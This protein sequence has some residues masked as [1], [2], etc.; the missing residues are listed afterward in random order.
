MKNILP[1]FLLIVLFIFLPIKIYSQT[2]VE[3]TQS[4][5]INF[6][7]AQGGF[8]Y[9]GGIACADFNNDNFTDIYI[10][11]A[12]GSPNQLY[13]NNGDLTFTEKGQFADVND[14]NNSW[15]TVAGDIDNDGDID[16]YLTNYK[17]PNRLYINDGTGKFTDNATL[18][19]VTGSVAGSDSGY[20]SSATMADFDNDGYLDI[21]VLNRAQANDDYANNLYHN[22]GDGTFTD[23]TLWANP[24]ELQTA[25]AVGTCDYDNDGYM[26]IYVANEF[27]L[28]GF[29]HNNKNNSFSDLGP[30]L[31]IP[32]TAGMG[33]DYTDFDHDGDFEIYITNLGNDIF[34]VNNGDGTVTNKNSVVGITNGSMTWGVNIADYNNDGYDDIYSVNGGMM[35]PQTYSQ[36]N[37]YYKNL[38]NGTFV[39]KADL[40]GLGS[41]LGD[42]RASSYL[43]INNDGFMDII[44]LNILRDTDNPSD[45]VRGKAHLYLNQG[46]NNNWISL[47]LIGVQSNKSAVGA[48]VKLEAGNLTQL[49][50]VHSGSSFGSMHC[51]E[52]GFGLKDNTI[53]DKLTITWPSGNVQELTNVNVNQILTITENN[54]VTG[55]D[56]IL[57]SPPEEF[58][59]SQNYPNP[60]NPST[61]IQFS[62]KENS[63]VSLKIFDILGKEIKTLV[64]EELDAGN[65][66]YKFNTSN[67][68]EV[69]PSGIYFYRLVADSFTDTKK[70]ILLK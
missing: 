44:F 56:E 47:K 37:V 53:I 30:A 43:D 32:Q 59:L 48:R 55:I 70:M 9:L 33:V 46:T 11:N 22:N 25:L 3:I 34:L 19:G 8:P 16:I 63:F 69:L 35:W 57:S 38:G 31:N 61:Q 15:G 65:Y 66:K 2:F 17:A 41:N 12:A 5:G 49:K 24:S 18:A 27:E 45:T 26:D 54:T 50:E 29:L 60:F 67:S 13:M 68:I 21:Y 62:I 52:L 20:S 6:Q 64:N 23:M 1:K 39:E 10:V 7:H 42:S 58:K 14:N 28:D 51:L 40:V 36:K 4:A